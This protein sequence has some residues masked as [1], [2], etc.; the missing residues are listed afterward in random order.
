[1]HIQGP[2]IEI[3]LIVREIMGYKN[4][5][6]ARLEVRGSSNLTEILLSA[7]DGDIM[8]EDVIRI[9]ITS[10]GWRLKDTVRIFYQA[11]LEYDMRYREYNS[12][13]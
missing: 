12:E 3:D 5:K 13:P 6:R 8:L 9:G 1:M 7:R 11:P 10:P 2:D 4:S